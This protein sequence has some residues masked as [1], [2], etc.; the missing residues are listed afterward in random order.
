MHPRDSKSGTRLLWLCAFAAFVVLASFYTRTYTT[1]GNAD[2]LSMR[3]TH[4]PFVLEVTSAIGPAARAGIKS[5]DT[6]D[7]RTLPLQVG[8][9]VVN[10]AAN[11]SVTRDGRR[12]QTNIYPVLP[13]LTWDEQGRVLADFWTVLF[14]SLI[15][16]RGK[17]WGGSA[18]L[19]FILVLGVLGDALSRSVAPYPLLT[20]V[21]HALGLAIFGPLIF[22]LLARYFA[23]FGL[24]RSP[25][26][27]I[28]TRVAYLTSV[29]SVLVISAHYI[30]SA[31]IWIPAEYQ[32]GEFALFEL[33]LTLPALPCAV[34]GI[35]AARA[36]EPS[37]GQR[38]GWVVLSYGIFWAFWIL[39]GPL[40]PVW[41]SATD[42]VW[43]LEDAAHLFVPLGLSYAALRRRLFDVGFVVNRAAVF[44]AISS[45]LIGS[46]VLL[47]WAIGKWFEGINHAT[48]TALNVM[49]ALALGVSMRFMHRRVDGLIDSVFFRKRHENERA[50]RRFAREATLVTDR[51]VLLARTSAEILKH[52]EISS[53]AILFPDKLDPND[54]ALLALRAWHEPIELARYE[55]AIAGE[56]AFPMDAHGT[57][58]GAIVCGLKGNE[59]AYAPDEI[60]ALNELAKGVG[61]AIWSLDE[62]GERGDILV[63]L[64]SEL[65]ALRL[66]VS[67]LDGG[68]RSIGGERQP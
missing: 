10:T 17:R 35:L 13:R 58:L 4:E 67:A 66:S 36:A 25:A 2:G 60:D 1:W 48:S 15:A 26:R 28:W 22:A 33:L 6:I 46:F 9:G 8:G 54:P 18:S 56:Y 23:G 5:G 42:A 24:P 44:T 11:V 64:L 29:L 19:A 53:V 63:E 14:A 37:D 31:T 43:S 12:I 45:I 65:R 7:R 47:E 38:V 57:F 41:G 34:C 50:L 62:A 55:S 49:L 52:S 30:S 40:S 61:L 39:A 27:N 59:E 21:S 32:R 51:D 20:V 16:W 68:A 3:P